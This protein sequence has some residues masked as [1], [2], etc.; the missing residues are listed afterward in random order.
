VYTLGVTGEASAVIKA[1]TTFKSD[2]G[3]LYILD[4]QYTLTGSNDA[5]EIRALTG[6]TVAALEIGEVLTATAPIL[7]VDR[8]GTVSAIDTSP[9]DAESIDDYR[10]KGIEAYQLEPQ[11]GAASDYRIWASDANG[12]KTVYPYASGATANSIDLY[13]EGNSGDGTVSQTVLDDV[14]AVIEQDPDTSKPLSE[15][16][17]RPLGILQVNAL[18]VVPVLLEV[19]ITGLDTD[20]TA[21]RTA[22]ENAISAYLATVRPF[23]PGADVLAD[24]NDTLTSS[25]LALAVQEAIGTGNYFNALSFTANSVSLNAYNFTNG[26][27]PKLDSVVY[28]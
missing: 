17:R 22:I 23:I 6:G 1:G 20:T 14:A 27:I 25:K 9:V 2:A 7:D 11:G 4:D 21:I 19:T 18:S 13:V 10:A 15:R 16:G 5:I 28:N 3:R 8:Q 26:R 24:R 12:V